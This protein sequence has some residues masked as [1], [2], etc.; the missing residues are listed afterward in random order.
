[1]HPVEYRSERSSTDCPCACSGERYCAVPMTAEVWVIV[2]LASAMARAMP[3]SMTLTS[4]SA[5]I[6]TLAGL[7]SR[8]TIPPPLRVAVGQ[9]VE[10]TPSVIRSA[11]ARGRSRA[12]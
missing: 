2:A 8:W 6:M 3:K 1:M 4:P 12:R 11:S 7:M 5:P 10:Q 9:G